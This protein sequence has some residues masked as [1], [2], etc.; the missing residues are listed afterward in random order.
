MPLKDESGN[1][2]SILTASQLAGE[3]AKLVEVGK[4]LSL[5]SVQCDT[6]SLEVGMLGDACRRAEVHAERLK[7]QCL[8]S[9]EAL[10]DRLRLAQASVGA[11]GVQRATYPYDSN[12]YA[13]LLTNSDVP[14]PMWDT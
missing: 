1:S 12:M 8:A 7:R 4:E 13:I 2:F 6:L 10:K 3:R 11:A 5:K 14:S 9:N